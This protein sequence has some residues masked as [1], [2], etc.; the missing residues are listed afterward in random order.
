MIE[1]MNSGQLIK[2]GQPTEDINNAG[3]TKGKA[4]NRL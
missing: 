4:P 1:D 3:G 2:E